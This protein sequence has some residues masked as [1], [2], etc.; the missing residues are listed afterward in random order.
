M[1][2]KK[3]T[4]IIAGDIAVDWIGWEHEASESGFGN[5]GDIH[6]WKLW[7]GLR[8]VCQEGGVLLIN[9]FLKHA[10]WPNG[11]K[12]NLISYILNSPEKIP[13]SEIIHSNTILSSYPSEKEKEDKVWRV[14]RY[15]GFSGPETFTNYKLKQD[16]LQPD[17]VILDD[18]GNGFRDHK[19]AWPASIKRATGSPLIVLKMSRPLARGG[20]WKILKK[21][22]PNKL[23]IIVSAKDLR[24]SGIFI[25][26]RLSWERTVSDLLWQLKNNKKIKTLA[27]S[28][29]LIIRFGIEGVLYYRNTDGNISADLFYTPKFPEDGA[30]DIFAGQMQ[31]SFDSFTA[32][33][34]THLIDWNGSV[35]FEGIVEG[36][37]AEWRL[38]R[39][40]FGPDSIKLNEKDD[41][42]QMY[43][44]IFQSTKDD[45]KIARISIPDSV[46]YFYDPSGSWT[47]LD[48]VIS[49]GIEKIADEQIRTGKSKVMDLV[50]V[51]KWAKLIT[52]DR[53]EIES[54]QSIRNLILQY[55]K[56]PS[57]LNPLCIS[58]FGPPGSG[59]SF[60]VKQLAAS[61]DSDAIKD[62]TFNLSQAGNPDALPMMFHK[63]RDEVLKGKIPLVFFDEFDITLQNQ[64][65]GWLKYFLAPMQDGEFRDGEGM[66]PIGRSIFIFAGGT[67]QNFNEFKK[68]IRSQSLHSR[69]VRGMAG[70]QGRCRGDFVLSFSKS[71]SAS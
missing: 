33:L 44:C 53:S 8:M 46:I 36:I 5:S 49:E 62:I 2:S 61:I 66:H 47:I 31:G 40:G 19:E 16:P 45:P 17:I 12:P 11:K 64:Q 70:I 30:F 50:P 54:F 51:G 7:P 39:H 71:R 3:K 14:K 27:S 42:D 1:E 18:C 15:C 25:S 35:P 56:N 43:S 48:T 38:Y 57:V 67:C 37:A 24:E 32:A 69:R 21:K 68:R 55:I 20:L 52:I 34:V 59:K 6:N 9:S 65:F 10:P 4:I 22:D 28:A 58:V 60:G 13:P 63:I 23:I 41:F 29:H 26:H